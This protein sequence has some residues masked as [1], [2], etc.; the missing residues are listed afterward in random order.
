[1][2][3]P[4]NIRIETPTGRIIEVCR[5]PDSD[6]HTLVKVYAQPEPS[7]REDPV[8]FTA[9]WLSRENRAQMVRALTGDPEDQILVSKDRLEKLEQLATQA[10]ELCDEWSR[11]KKGA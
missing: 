9:V 5:K 11:L 10:Q 3:N 6:D 8:I 1:M 2:T 7:D 4:N